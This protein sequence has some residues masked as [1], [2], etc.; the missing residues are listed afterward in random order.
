M[1]LSNTWNVSIRRIENWI[2]KILFTSNNANLNCYKDCCFHLRWTRK[3]PLHFHLKNLNKRPKNIKQ[4]FS[5]YWTSSNKEERLLRNGKQTRWVL[6]LPQHS[7]LRARPQCRERKPRQSPEDFQGWANKVE[8][9]KKPRLLESAE[10]GTREKI[11]PYREKSADLQKIPLSIEQRM[12]QH[13][14][15]AIP[16]AR[17]T[18]HKRGSESVAST[19]STQQGSV[20]ALAGSRL[21]AIQH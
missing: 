1:W 19:S 18:N 7:A 14:Y 6:W 11:A 3:P 9:P 10:K 21:T 13:L 2:F 15:E 20:G 12:D 5:R 4:C 16:K 8:S 17:G